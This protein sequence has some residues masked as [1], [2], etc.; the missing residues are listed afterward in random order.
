[1]KTAQ[2]VIILIVVIVSLLLLTKPNLN[3]NPSDKNCLQN[4][5]IL[6]EKENGDSL[7]TLEILVTD[8]IGS[9]PQEGEIRLGNPKFNDPSIPFVTGWFLG[10]DG[11][12]KIIPEECL[13]QTLKDAGFQTKPAN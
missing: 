10:S 8:G 12:R 5:E 13:V 7:L 2:L 4:V 9:N 1:M 6:E 3:L 11:K